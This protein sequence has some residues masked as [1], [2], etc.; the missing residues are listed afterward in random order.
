[1]TRLRL[2]C[3][4]L[5]LL[6]AVTAGFAPPVAAENA[7]CATPP[8]DADWAVSAPEAAGFDARALCAVLE[9]AAKETANL[10]AVLVERH[11]KLVAELYRTGHD[12][13]IDVAYGLGNPFAADV[14]FD[15]NALH[16]VRSISKSVVGLLVGIAVRDGKIGSLSSSVLAVYPELADLRSEGRDAITIEQLLTMSSGLDWNE[17]GAG[18]LTSDETRLFWNSDQVRFAFDRAL[19]A[20]PGTRFDY[21]G[22]GT[23]TLADLLVRTTGKPLVELARAELFEP[24][25]ITHWEWARDYRDRPLAFAGLR[26]RPRDMAKLGRLVLDRGRWRERQVVPE[27]WIA[28]SLRPHIS[29]GDAFPPDPALPNAYGYQWWAGRIAWRGRDLAWNT[30]LGNGGQRIYVVPELDLT[31]VITAGSYGKHEIGRTV[32]HI[33]AGVVA[34]TAE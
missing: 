34:A 11:G 3:G 22:G 17:W 33:F 2:R 23:A 32:A 20:A 1:M 9:E 24:L 31:V 19:V 10:H 30:A 27:A 7:P 13:P 5:A 15:A 25:G 14:A 29:T 4:W 12:D 8:A 26:M 28:E 6:A 21:N 18:T 16:D